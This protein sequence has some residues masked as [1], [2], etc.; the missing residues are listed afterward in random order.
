AQYVNDGIDETDDFAGYT[1]DFL[2]AHLVSVSTSPT[3]PEF[4]GLWRVLRDSEGQLKFYLN[5]GGDNVDPLGPLT[6]D[7]DVVSI[8]TDRLEL[9]HINDDDDTMDTLVFERN[10]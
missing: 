2:T 5:F 9:K 3:G 6:N 8:T 1:F 10:Q 4:P 7:W